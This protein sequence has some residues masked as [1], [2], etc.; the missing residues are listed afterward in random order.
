MENNKN[1][2]KKSIEMGQC[3]TVNG[4]PGVGLSL[5]LK[6]LCEEN[7]AQFYYVDIFALSQVNTESLFKELSHLLGNNDSPNHIEEIQQSLKE[8]IQSKPIVICFAGF[9]KLEKNLTKK[10]FDDLRAIRN[11]DRSKIIFIFGVC[12]RIET[13]IPESVMDSDISMFSKKLYLTPFSLDECEYLLQKYGPK[14][15]RENITLSGGHFQL[16]QLLIQ[17]E[18]PTNPLNDQFIELCL[19]NIYL[20][21]T[22]GQR[23][24]LQKISGGKNPAQIDPYL[25]HIGIIN[26]KNDFFSSLFQTFVQNQQSKKIP[27]KEG[28]LFRLLKAR[29]GTIVNKTD[30]FRTV[31][32]ESSGDTTDWALDSLI[33]RLRKNETFQKSGYYIESVKK[34]GYILIKN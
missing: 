2:I 4:M 3:V 11:T 18:F 19:K 33:Y 27:A 17:T 6:E 24:V 16:L 10:L 5:F 25:M 30:I 15:D 21:L 31:W 9:D 13:I 34:Q 12:K 1:E 20:H 22:I 8:K 26:S 32:G 23:K 14:L 7:F 28:K 29:L